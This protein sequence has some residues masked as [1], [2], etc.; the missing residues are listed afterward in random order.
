M[1]IT[2]KELEGLF[3]RLAKAKGWTVEYNDEGYYKLDHYNPGGAKYVWRITKVTKGESFVFPQGGRRLTTSE[4]YWA[5]NALLS[6][7]YNEV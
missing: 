2:R 7:H 4:M 3:N 5:I 1:R 6:V